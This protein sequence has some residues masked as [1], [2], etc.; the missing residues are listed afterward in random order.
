MPNM[1]ARLYRR[2]PP[3]IRNYPLDVM[4]AMM[5]IPSGVFSLI[6]I[7]PQSLQKLLP[8][9]IPYLWSIVLVI[10]CT[11]WLIG[12]LSTRDIDPERRVV[13]IVRTPMT[14]LGVTLVSSA[15]FVY[16]CSIIAFTGLSGVV[17]A[18]PLFTVSIGAYLRRINILDMETR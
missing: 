11:A 7:S 2:L 3:G 14:V 15:A 1:Q 12:I 17:V 6:G 13:A 9:G 8:F 18:T 10:G 4:F 5:G 16:G